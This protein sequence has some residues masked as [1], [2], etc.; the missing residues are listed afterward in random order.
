MQLTES[1]LIIWLALNDVPIQIVDTVSVAAS[2]A[3]RYAA[4]IRE[5]V[6]PVMKD[7]GAALIELRMTSPEI[8][9]DVLIQS[10][11]SVADHAEWNRVRRNFFMDPRWLAAW[12][13]AAP[14]RLS[15]TRR[16]Y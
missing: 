7:A 4:M 5:S 9:E 14:L 1:Q 3:R 2:D 15:G 12:A 6:A 8:G 13:K 10:V 16:F 11:W